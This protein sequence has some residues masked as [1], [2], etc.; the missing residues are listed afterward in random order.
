M[1]TVY[2]DWEVFWNR[3]EKLEAVLVKQCRRQRLVG[4]CI[5]DAS[6]V[7]L[8]ALAQMSKLSW[9]RGCMQAEMRFRHWHNG[10]RSRCGPHG[11]SRCRLHLLA[12]EEALCVHKGRIGPAFARSRPPGRSMP[13][14]R[15]SFRALMESPDAIL[16]PMRTAIL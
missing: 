16:R 7:G 13:P 3:F 5:V 2:P 11:R 9:D 1:R 4:T 10:G 15:Q 12:R 6:A 8:D 14:G